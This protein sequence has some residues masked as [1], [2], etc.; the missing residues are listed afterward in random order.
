MLSSLDLDYG[1]FLIG[2][3]HWITYHKVL[4]RLIPHWIVLK[5]IH[6][7]HFVWNVQMVHGWM[8]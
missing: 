7:Q 1:E 3:L 5:E 2:I 6:Q 8:K 4:K